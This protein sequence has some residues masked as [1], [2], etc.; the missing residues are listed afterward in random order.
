MPPQLVPFVLV[1]IVLTVVP[2]PDTAL[3]LRNGARGGSSAMW[4]TGLGACSGL[5]VHAAASVIGLSALLAASA[6]T[7]TV[8]K[9]AGAAYL[10]WLGVSTLWSTRRRRD[11]VPLPL[12]LP[13]HGTLGP[14]DDGHR[15]AVLDLSLRAWEPVFPRTRAAVPG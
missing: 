3:G 5:C 10:V 1:V 9:V 12:P 6:E 11:P 14:Y 13:L 4:W 2:G 7:Y 15:R 8:V